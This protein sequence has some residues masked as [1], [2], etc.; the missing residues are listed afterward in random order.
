[1][2]EQAKNPLEP[3]E[4]RALSSVEFVHD[5]VQLRFDG[6][7]LTAIALVQVKSEITVA[8]LQPGYR[9]ALCEQIGKRVRTAKSIPGEQIRLDFD[10]GSSISISLEPKDWTRAE[11]AIL[12]NPPN[13]MVV[14]Q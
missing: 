6:P 7:T 3:L 8:S 5:Y 12:D 4:G 14:W 2:N 11:S 10:D 13:P 9:D 1:M